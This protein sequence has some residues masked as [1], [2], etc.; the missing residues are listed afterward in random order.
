MKKF[1]PELMPFQKGF[2]LGVESRVYHL[3]MSL[4]E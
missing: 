4:E 1:I 3:K 2:D